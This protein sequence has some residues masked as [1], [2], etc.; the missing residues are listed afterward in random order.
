MT[1][2]ENYDSGNDFVLEYGDLRFTFNDSDFKQRAEQAAR[3]VKIIRGPL[4]LDEELEDLQNLIVN[5]EIGEAESPLG[6]HL[7]DKWEEV[8]DYANEEG[9][10]VH[11]LRRLVFRQA[12][13]DQRVIE[14]ELGV[15]FDDK[16]MDF[17]YVQPDRD[18]GP[19]V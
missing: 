12:W 13:L 16:A 4:E 7:T 3:K 18:D 9:S 11:W 5:G 8:A 6:E 1:Q 2:R 15:V 10:L 17:V 19:L 14:G